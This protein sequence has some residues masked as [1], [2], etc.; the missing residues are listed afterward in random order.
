MTSAA[1]KKKA[2]WSASTVRV[3]AVRLQRHYGQSVSTFLMLVQAR[4]W[5]WVLLNMDVT[6]VRAYM[7]WKSDAVDHGCFSALDVDALEIGCSWGRTLFWPGNERSLGLD[8]DAY[9]FGQNASE[10]QNL[11]D[12]SSSVASR[13]Q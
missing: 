8:V 12:S 5:G 13:E 2:G 10:L 11:V 6:M 7:F 9:E 1:S 3:R 4:V